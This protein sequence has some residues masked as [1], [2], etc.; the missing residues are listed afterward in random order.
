[1]FIKRVYIATIAA[2]I[3]TSSADAADIASDVS[4]G[5][6]GFDN[7]NGGYFEFGV[8]VNLFFNR[9]RGIVNTSPMLAG[10]YRYRGF[11]LEAISP[12]ISINDG[13]V[14]GVTLGL[15]IWRNERW[16]VD[17]LGANSRFRLSRKTFWEDDSDTA[18]LE[19]DRELMERDSFYNGAGARVTG[20]FGNTIFQYRLVSDTFGGNG[21]TSSARIGHSR[22]LRNWNIHGV[23]RADH[24]SQNTGQYWYGVSEE[25][26][27]TR[28]QEYKV[29]SST[30]SYSAEFGATY[31]VRE[32]VVFR[33]TG[34]YTQFA[35]A[36][37]KS[38]LQEG[39]STFRWNTSLSY[40]F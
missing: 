2:L 1:M 40:V 15:N 27:T 20:Y 17:L 39:E 10:A 37:A 4:A 29:R 8:G 35:D 30:I 19:K 25:E 36:I 13:T 7:S 12:G 33:S 22:Q 21:V 11:F 26:A 31:P 9:E 6:G 3:G 24:V 32:N 18:P 38:P 23:F 28:F 34:R 16:A 14:G 5:S